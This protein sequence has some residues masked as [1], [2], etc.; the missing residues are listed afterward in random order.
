MTGTLPI[1]I[2]L[3]LHQLSEQQG[4]YPDRPQLGPED[5][6]WISLT[7]AEPTNPFSSPCVPIPNG[8][9]GPALIF[10]RRTSYNGGCPSFRGVRKLGT[11]G[12]NSVCSFVR[13]EAQ[14]QWSCEL[15]GAGPS[16]LFACNRHDLGCL[17]SQSQ[18]IRRLLRLQFFRRFSVHSVQLR[19]VQSRDRSF[20]PTFC[21]TERPL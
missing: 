8:G 16:L 19:A 13:Y 4:P 3:T 9:A 20:P 10:S 15:V 21:G 12:S 7:T 17:L 6:L 2:C 5:M 18:H 14:A 11:T 1:T